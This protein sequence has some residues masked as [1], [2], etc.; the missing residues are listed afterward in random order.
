VIVLAAYVSQNP[1]NAEDIAIERDVQS[2]PWGPLALTFPVY[3]Y[4]GDSRG[5]VLEL[6]LFIVILLVNRPAW[7]VA[8]GSWV[9]ALWYFTVSHLIIRPR[10][11][12]ATVLQ[13]TEH[14][15]ASSFPSGHTIF[16]TTLVVVIVVCIAYR[17]LHGWGRVA[18]WIAGAAV[19]AG[20]VIDRIDSGAHWPSDVLAGLLIAT[21]WLSIWIS[22]PWV[23]SRIA[24]PARRSSSR[25]EMRPSPRSPA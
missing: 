2:V 20:N 12:T 21:A 16:T 4:I 25:S 1:V 14:P 15:G 7:V 5:F 24:N 23:Y 3:S 8:A 18:A 19:V 6:A 10:P 17:Y 11:T 22:I 9:S 13:V